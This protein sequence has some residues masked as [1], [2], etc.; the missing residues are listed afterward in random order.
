MNK[1]ENIKIISDWYSLFEIESVFSKEDVIGYIEVVL[2][3][4]LERLKSLKKEIK[5]NYKFRIQT[6]F[7]NYFAF[8]LGYSFPEFYD[9]DTIVLKDEVKLCQHFK[10][11]IARLFK[12]ISDD[13]FND[14]Y[15]LVRFTEKKYCYFFNYLEQMRTA[16]ELSFQGVYYS[17]PEIVNIN[18]FNSFFEEEIKRI[19]GNYVDKKKV[20]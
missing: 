18:S 3:D 19:E 8:A 5:Q 9:E 16:N 1:E 6:M 11:L 4:Y 20:L 14:V 10:D 13:N 2:D 12:I 17:V 15:K 7:A